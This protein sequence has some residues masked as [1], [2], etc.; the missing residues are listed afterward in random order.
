MSL[1]LQTWFSGPV[2]SALL[3]VGLPA[4]LLVALAPQLLGWLLVLP[5]ALA[6]LSL[7][8]VAILASIPGASIAVDIDGMVVFAPYVCAGRAI[9]GVVGRL[10]PRVGEWL[11][12]CCGDG[13]RLDGA[14]DIYGARAG[15]VLDVGQGDAI[16][17]RE[18]AACIMV[19]AGD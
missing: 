7:F 2:M 13:C 18:G 8:L 1:R 19:D 3:T 14:L 5:L 9:S 11:C 12:A 15:I 16:V 6:R 10:A 4:V 17:L